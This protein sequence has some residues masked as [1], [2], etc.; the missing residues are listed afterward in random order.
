MRRT[1]RPGREIPKDYR[2]V[3]VDL[4]DRQG[5]RYDKSGK[6]YPRLYPPS[7][8]R[9]LSVPTTPSASLRALKNWIAEVRRRGGLWPPRG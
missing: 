8:Q 6:G 9:A 3:I 1:D 4:I 2:A 7:G 5:W